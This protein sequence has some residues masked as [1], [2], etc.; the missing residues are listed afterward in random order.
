MELK[1][2]ESQYN[3]IH[4][5]S[6]AISMVG[7]MFCTWSS[8]T[9]EVRVM[10]DGMFRTKMHQLMSNILTQGRDSGQTS[11]HHLINLKFRY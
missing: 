5:K 4:V 8:V 7:P 10:A 3:G 9:T 6:Y 11:T 2:L 1:S